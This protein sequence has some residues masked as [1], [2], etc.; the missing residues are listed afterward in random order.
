MFAPGGG[1]GAL[2][3][4][5]EERPAAFHAAA[6]AV[7]RL[8]GRRD[9]GQELGEPGVRKAVDHVGAFVPALDEARL[10]QDFQVVAHRA[11]LHGKVGDDLAHGAFMNAKEAEG[12]EP[13]GVAERLEKREFVRAAR[14]PLERYENFFI[15]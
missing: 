10:P 4:G 14:R 13:R 2:G 11:L 15:S 9:I 3:V 5:P 7:E 6:Y 1:E 12:G 8:G